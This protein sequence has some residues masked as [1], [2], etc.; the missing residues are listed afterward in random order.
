MVSAFSGVASRIGGLVSPVVGRVR[1]VMGS[2]ASAA[3]NGA[4]NAIAAFR[5]VVGGIAGHFSG[6]AGAVGSRL[7]GIASAARSA[8]SNVVS[9]F[10]GL[11]GRILAAIGHIIIHPTISMPSIPHIHIPGTAVGGVFQ[12]LRGTGVLRRIGEEGPE[13]V[14]P[15]HRPLSQVDPAV[16]A[17]SAFAQGKIPGMASGGVSPTKTV[18]ASGWTIITPNTDTRAV[19]AE[20]LN[21]LAA[22]VV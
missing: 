5:G 9:A 6:V 21:T 17:L 2:V 16:R 15:L 19:A 22:K 7:A 4:S 14:V 8:A 3:R 12:G 13:A 1:S 18:D 10:A 20:V 11:G